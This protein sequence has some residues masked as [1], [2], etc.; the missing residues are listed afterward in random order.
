MP[1]VTRAF[2]L[3]TLAAGKGPDASGQDE[4]KR[5]F[6]QIQSAQLTVKLSLW[7]AFRTMEKHH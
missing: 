1:H 5:Y 7:E 6:Q 4:L 3:A 2:D